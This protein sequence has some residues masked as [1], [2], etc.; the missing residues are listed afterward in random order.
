MAENTPTN[1]TPSH[2]QVHPAIAALGNLDLALKRLTEFLSSIGTIWFFAL[3]ILICT[4]VFLRE[5]FLSPIRGVT[6][7]V[8][9]HNKITPE[10]IP[11]PTEVTRSLVEEF[12]GRPFEYTEHLPT[13]QNYIS[14]KKAWDVTAKTRALAD[15]CLVLFNSNEFIYVY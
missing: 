1:R 2:G 10:P 5:I 12:S 14:D 4:E 7:M 8:A 6:E 3:V 11:Y 9:Y 15:V 13:Y